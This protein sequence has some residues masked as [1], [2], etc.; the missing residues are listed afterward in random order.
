MKKTTSKKISNRLLKYSAFSAA[1]LGTANA[2]GQIIYTDIS[3]ETV[4]PGSSYALDLNNDLTG[5]FLFTINSAANFAF[6]QPVSGT[7]ATMYNSNGFVGFSS[8]PYN[9]PS[10]LTA[11]DLIN[12]TNG[13]FSARGDF[14][15]SSC[16]Y[17]GSQFC[18]GLDGY[19]GLTLVVGVDTFY[20]W[21]RIQVASD[22]SDMIIKDYAYNSIPGE[23]IEAGQTLSVDDF[24]SNT[25]THAYNKDTDKLTLESSNLPLSNID[26]FNILG[27]RV[28]NQSL[29]NS[30]ETIDMSS[31]TDGIYLAK[32]SI[33]GK[34]QT[35][36]ILKQ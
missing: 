15:Y 30:N 11:G 28:I 18:D 19:V 27:Q 1:I 20:G 35:I 29:S 3:D 34:T 24:E 12:A 5:D 22:T 13:I 32:V 2:S 6:M 36:K 9:Y 4:L 16:G 7:A 31:L 8:G 17:P 23:S 10:N 25:F 14:N 26:L 21:A 33:Q